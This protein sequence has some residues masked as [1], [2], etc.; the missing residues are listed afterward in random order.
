[1][2]LSYVNELQACPFQKNS[3]KTYSSCVARREVNHPFSVATIR[4]WCYS[5]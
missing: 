1:M 3:W 5:I 4:L 2:F